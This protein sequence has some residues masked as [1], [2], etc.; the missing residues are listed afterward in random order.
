MSFS[1]QF[2]SSSTPI[3]GSSFKLGSNTNATTTGNKPDFTVPGNS[4]AVGTG[5]LNSLG[6]PSTSK[7]TMS[8]SSPS[9]STSSSTSLF[10]NQSPSS[11]AS[12]STNSPRALY[13]RRRHGQVIEL[14]FTTP[15]AIQVNLIETTET[16]NTATG[17]ASFSPSKFL[18]SLKAWPAGS[19][20]KRIISNGLGNLVAIHGSAGNVSVLRLQGDAVTEEIELDDQSTL[21]AAV[22]SDFAAF[23]WHPASS[24]DHHLVILSK[25]GKI[26]IY[27]ILKATTASAGTFDSEDAIDT[28]NSEST[29]FLQLTEPEQTFKLPSSRT[30]P[31]SSISFINPP[32][33]LQNFLPFTAFL[34]RESGDIFAACPLL[35][36]K[37]RAQRQNHLLPLK[38]AE[39]DPI[40]L[41]WLDEVVR[42]CQFVANAAGD[43]DSVLATYPPS[44][45]HL[46]ARLQG[47]FLIQ[48]EP[49]EIHHLASYDRV[50][51]F[52]ASF[53]KVTNSPDPLTL[54]SVAFGS[55]KI[56]FLA[57][58]S[59]IA[60]KFQLKDA[61]VKSSDDSD[62][63]IL[64]LIESVDLKGSS[65]ERSTTHNRSID[66]QIRILECPG[67]PYFLVS[68]DSAV[69]K[70]NLQ[71]S[72]E[73]RDT[74]TD[75]EES[76]ELD[77]WSIDCESTIVIE[78]LKNH[79]QCVSNS[80]IYPG[81]ISCE[82]S[83]NTS[84]IPKVNQLRESS[85]LETITKFAFP[86]G[87]M[88]IEGGA[89]Q[90]ESLLENLMKNL[91]RLKANRSI[92]SKAKLP[93]IDEIGATEFND[94]VSEWQE[95]L[96]SPAIRFGHEIA[97]RSNELVQ[98]L[99]RER[100]ILVRAKTLLTAKPERL[101]KLLKSLSEAKT[102][103]K[104]L[105][106]RVQRISFELSKHSVYDSLL[107]EK[108]AEI[109]KNLRSNHP[110]RSHSQQQEE[111][112]VVLGENED[113]L[114][115]AQLE[116]Q[117]ERLM[118]LKNQLMTKK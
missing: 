91:Q 111:E 49:M 58:A 114:I 108:L 115:R 66:N 89:M 28:F 52:S 63:P 75:T 46:Q 20:P 56:D 47:P 99:R 10:T 109:S 54:L 104:L 88:D 31:F 94:H 69:I 67:C 8:T 107:I 81:A 68:T 90:L 59:E 23:A 38:Q 29:T 3:G 17:N 78:K 70:I 61:L 7:S 112:F 39:K 27:D 79:V 55:G 18:Y 13:C 118:K 25:S 85:I 101:E 102:K 42:S 105:L 51:D 110:L 9:A 19:T 2:P 100:E 15:S 103:N 11:T 24:A 95:A 60:P 76:E 36:L 50:V 71:I 64:A 1:F 44:F 37:F 48:P 34:V 98:I 87:K 83:F 93:E 16:G 33:S 86:L 65:E 30:D 82:L 80:K 21:N 106:E 5:I 4:G 84:S 97:L 74:Y 6:S 35:P 77:D 26:Y 62:L 45:S 73:L 117:T 53:F 14:N 32:Q 41:K 12:S 57:V 96:V 113:E 72:F 22:F 43:T 40:V 92:S 116:I